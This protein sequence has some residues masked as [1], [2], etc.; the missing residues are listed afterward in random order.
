MTDPLADLRTAMESALSAAVDAALDIRLA[1]GKGGYGDANPF[2]VL[3]ETMAWL[4][5][6]LLAIQA[7]DRYVLHGEQVGGLS[8]VEAAQLAQRREKL[9]TSY[10]TMRLRAIEVLEE[11]ADRP[12]FPPPRPLPGEPRR[13]L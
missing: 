9:L 6:E 5:M 13:L 10:Q 8:E 4:A 12:A 7:Q 1:E 11:L 2:M 3:K